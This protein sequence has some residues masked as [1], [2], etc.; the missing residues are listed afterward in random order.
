MP[1]NER[2]LLE[3]RINPKKPNPRNRNTNTTGYECWE[4]DIEVKAFAMADIQD[5]ITNAML[6]LIEIRQDPD[7]SITQLAFLDLLYQQLDLA[8]TKLCNEVTSKLSNLEL[9]IEED[10]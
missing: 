2:K 7:Y 9:G 6:M 1:E 4:T 3:L 5:H 8:D 10:E